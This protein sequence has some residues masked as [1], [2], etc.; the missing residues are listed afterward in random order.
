MGTDR[1]LVLVASGDS[2]LSA[3]R[4]CWPAQEELELAITRTFAEL[5][6]G[7]VRG[8]PFDHT[9]QH[10]FIDGQARG[11]EVFRAINPDAPLIVAE[12]V[13]QYTS[14]VLPGLTRHRGP[15]LTLANWSGQWPGLVGL[16]N[17]NGSL[18]KAGIRYSSIW[19]EDF[20]DAF[21]RNAIAEWLT[22]GTIRHDRSHASAVTDNTFGA[23][24]AAD[25]ARG[26]ALGEAL[27]RDQ[28]ILGVFD[29]GCMGMYN[30]II[31]DHLLHPT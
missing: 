24:H 2:R 16:L 14:H 28:A 6:R 10:G 23:A 15:I 4:V 26:Q 13:W 12:A 18:T 31:P 17:L 30:A 21:A 7:V 5:G 8:H 25:L 11:I 29:E 20:T 27:R 1:D 22:S 19:S 9:K 3:N